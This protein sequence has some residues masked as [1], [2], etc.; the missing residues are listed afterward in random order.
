MNWD[1]KLFCGEPDCSEIATHITTAGSQPG[2]PACDKHLPH[3]LLEGCTSEPLPDLAVLRRASEQ[4]SRVRAMV[5][6]W[7]ASVDPSADA[8]LAM[9]ALAEALET[10]TN[11]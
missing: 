10:G 5:C 4:L 9:T 3:W 2:E 7:Q 1:G 8:G 6:E 11:K